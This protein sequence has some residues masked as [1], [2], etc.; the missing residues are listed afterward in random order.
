MRLPLLFASAMALAA[1]TSH[2]APTGGTAASVASGP[3]AQGS[4]PATQAA[5]R[6]IASLPDRGHFL[7]YANAQP[8][9]ASA[10]TLRPVALSEA[11]ALRSIATGTLELQAPDGT[12]IRLR[13][14][15]HIEHKDG[16]WTW[17]GRPDGAQPGTEAIITFGEKAVF[18]TIPNGDKPALRITT[19][20]GRT[21]VLETDGKALAR[22][23]AAGKL[24][25]GRDYMALPPELAGARE[26][27]LKR[28]A[29]A[30]QAL[31]PSGAVPESATVDVVIGYTNTFAARLGGAS[32]TQTRLT[33][34]VDV[35]NAAF[36][37]S[38]IVAKL[39][40]VGSVALNYP[41]NTDNEV[42]LH[43]ATG[44]TCAPTSC[45]E[46]PVPSTL[47][48]LLNERAAKHAD[49]MSL[50]R[51]FTNPE[52][53]SCGIAWMLG[54]GRVPIT[55]EDDAYAAV[56]VVSDSSGDLLPDDGY[57]CR[58]ETFVHE[59]GH[60]M[61]SAH[62]RTT[63]A[64]DNG[65]L[66]ED[67]FG[68]FDYSFGYKNARFFTIMAYRDPDADPP[69]AGYRVFS[70][71]RITYCGEA[72][73][74]ADNDNA[75]SLGQTA[76]IIAGFYPSIA[77][78]AMRDDFDGSGR[79]D[80]MWRSTANGTNYLWRGASSASSQQLVTVTDQGWTVVGSG[81]FDAD[82]FAD[83]L[84]RNTRTG[85][86]TIWRSGNGN[87]ALAVTAVP[88]QAWV[89]SGVGDFDDDG[90]ADILWHNVNTGQSIIWRS[91]NGANAQTLTT[92]NIV[93]KIVGVGDFNADGSA[94]ILWRN[95]TTGANTIWRSG[96]AATQQSMLTVAA[97][98]WTVVGV[99]DFDNDGTSDIL[100]RNTS[101]GANL[102]WRA[103]NGATTTAVATVPDQNWKVARVADYNGDGRSDVLWRHATAGSNAI[104]LSANVSTT[105]AISAA[106]TVYVVGGN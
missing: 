33:Y 22:M 15:R 67:E 57:Y 44:V 46:A 106:A 16:N 78:S 51:I 66:D 62:D 55:R 32:P 99:G 91:G 79:A 37:N 50:V 92:A 41:D 45:T 27:A 5:A 36:N 47:Q 85:A 43:E 8:I 64:G 14:A 9:H 13:Y 7:D 84:W 38:Q 105:Q 76:P 42:A 102:V 11:H 63:A 59:V 94:D 82:G 10:Y 21:Y 12:P 96:N 104:W 72:C 40:L 90:H 88:S 1:C 4:A 39:R 70:N 100:W 68:A 81:D 29:A 71:P 73:G 58:D 101:T 61:G 83:L 95:S 77:Q 87:T 53:Q 89:V 93:W 18:G 86:N 98:A 26:V 24:P 52:N 48:P 6:T 31:T 56:S 2:D 49:V 17:I 65:V 75:R 34:L 28:A 54:S 19:A 35:A 3:R 23:Q 30:P 20:R 80:I 103:A 74:T 25:H 97:Q 60:N 69:Q